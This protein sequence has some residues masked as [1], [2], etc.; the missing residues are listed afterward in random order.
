MAEDLGWVHLAVL[1]AA[2]AFGAVVPV[3]PTGPALAAAAV[4]A[5]DEAPWE[6]VLVLAVGWLGAYLGDLVVF[7]LFSFTG[8]RIAQR[9]PWLHADRPAMA[10]MGRRIEAN[11]LATMTTSRLIPA[12]RLPVLAAA[13][14]SGYPWHRFALTA[15][16]SAGAWAVLYVGIGLLGGAV[17]PSTTVA[18]VAAVLVAL[19]IGVVPRLV[20][21]TPRG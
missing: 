2:V 6:I 5:H 17:V 13:A 10:A 8:G 15:V 3:V 20:T 11:D 16:A 4:L 12:G 7:A 19:A 18:L 1:L 14:V 9:V 21:R